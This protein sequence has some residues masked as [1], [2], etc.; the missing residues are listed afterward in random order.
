[1]KKI[2][3]L[4]C[5]WTYG[6]DL[7]INE[8][9]SAHL[10]NMLPGWQVLNAGHSGADIEYA[11]FSAI[12]L[13]DEV[14]VDIVIFQLSSFDRMTLGT[15]GYENFLNDVFYNGKDESIYYESDNSSYTR[16]IGIADNI[17]TKFT[18]G[19]LVVDDVVSKDEF[20]DS[21]IKMVD[22]VSYRT[23]VKV[24][25]ENISFS[26]YN[27]QKTMTFLLTFERYLKSKSIKSLYFSYLPIPIDITASRYYKKFAEEVNFIKDDWKTWVGKN[28]PYN[29]FFI[30]STHINNEGNKILAEKYILPY[31]LEL[32]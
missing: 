28:Y 12:N 26:T 8:T 6:H 5:S 29:N 16:V 24:L 3:S 1:M 4:G 17:K 32:I 22:F 31:L 25:T 9:Y 30:D 14:D 15:D 10:Q 18:I 7:K 19:S 21:K 20:K 23:F 27:F 2:I 13:I 11:I